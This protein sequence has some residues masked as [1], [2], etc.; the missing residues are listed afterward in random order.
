MLPW[1]GKRSRQKASP[2]TLSTW[3]PEPILSAIEQGGLDLILS[4]YFLP[5]FDGLSALGI[6][7]EKSPAVPFIF[8]SRSL[9][10]DAA[11][12]SL[13]LGAT[14]YV[15]SQRLTRLAP[16]VAAPSENTKSTMSG[17]RGTGT[18]QQRRPFPSAFASAAVGMALVAPDGRWLQV[19]RSLCDIVGYSEQELLTKTFQDITHPDDLETDLG[20]VRQMLAGEI[21]TYQMEKRYFHKQGHVVWILFSVS[22][23]RDS[24][25]EPLYFISQIQNITERKRA[26]EQVNQNA[27]RAEALA[28][29][30]A[31][32][33]AQLDL[34][35]VLNAVCEET[36]RA[37]KVEA[38]LINLYD[39]KRDVLDVASTRG[40]P[41]EFRGRY[42]SPSS[43]LL[44]QYAKRIGPMTVIPE[45]PS[46][47]RYAEQRSLRLGQCPH[48][49]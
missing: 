30:A 48:C 23:V 24:N 9:G 4:A 36:T 41:P 3:I 33:N 32:L 35:A 2:A 21:R 20:Y 13:K 49:C 27:A 18:A 22:L 5:S 28:R 26:E 46:A 43:A 10:E 45:R 34:D 16:S 1:F 12:E 29:I 19:N 6:A 14:D 37:V 17:C 31:R 44:E 42:R 25:G 40:L 7:R 15:L 47:L 38:A 8:V 39:P 11:I